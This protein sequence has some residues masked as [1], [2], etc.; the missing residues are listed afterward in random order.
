MGHKGALDEY[1]FGMLIQ[2]P[3]FLHKKKQKFDTSGDQL[4]EDLINVVVQFYPCLKFYFHLFWG[5]VMY[6]LM[7]LKQR[8]IQ[9]KTKIKLNYNMENTLRCD[10]S[11]RT[12]FPLF[13]VSNGAIRFSEFANFFEF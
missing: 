13:I 4:V 10:H 3:I 5:M 1:N 6:I 2:S 11:N 8:K 7:S 12:V 9:F